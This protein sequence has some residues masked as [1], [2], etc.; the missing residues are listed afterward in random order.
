MEVRKSLVEAITF[1]WTWI[2]I[3]F[4]LVLFWLFCGFFFKMRQEVAR[5]EVGSESDSFGDLI[6]NDND[7]FELFGLPFAK[8]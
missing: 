6:E 1:L 4:F 2:K 8:Q 5:E 7:V 3:P